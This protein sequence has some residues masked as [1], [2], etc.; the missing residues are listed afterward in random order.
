VERL[1]L[2]TEE[3]LAAREHHMARLEALYAGERLERALVLAGIR[4][5]SG[6]SGPADEDPVRWVAEALRS[7]AEAPARAS[8]PMVFRPLFLEHWYHGVHFLDALFG[9]R[10]VPTTQEGAGGWW[11][12]CLRSPVGTLRAPDL[13]NS[14]VWRTAKALAL[15]MRDSGTTLP[16]L[17]PQV[18]AS[19]LNIA[20]NLYGEELLVAVVTDP[21]AARHDLRAITDTIKT[22]TAWYLETMPPAQ[23]QPIAV[24][25]RCQPRG[26]GQI[27]GCTS[28]LL[29]AA[30]YRDLV[31]PLDAEILSSYPRKAG[32]IHLCGSHTQHL[33][34]WRE[35]KALRAVQ[36]ND[37]A[38]EDFPLYFA[39]LR[40]DQIIYLRPTATMTIETALAISGGRRLVIATDLA[41]APILG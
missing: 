26:F 16:F 29:S 40:D 12:E 4:G 10:V 41:T 21:D 38:A 14:P 6:I 13:G 31:A 33:P 9:A 1:V 19:P 25:G 11:N 30:Q 32:M 34:V 35:M 8:D 24:A 39:G 5:G 17:A 3:L 28:Q 18:L 7:F 15:A 36:L 27:C 20:V 22:L 2:N 23:Y 37:R